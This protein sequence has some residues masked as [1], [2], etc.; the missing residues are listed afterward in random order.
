[1]PNPSAHEGEPNLAPAVFTVNVNNLRLRQSPGANGKELAK[2]REGALL[3]DL[4][5]VSDFTTKV[6]FRGILFDE[7]WLKVQMEDGL[8]GWVYAGGL[9]FDSNHPGQI[10]QQLHQKRL[11]AMFG[12][13]LSQRVLQYRNA[14]QDTKNDREMAQVYLEGSALR[15]TLVDLL[16]KHIAIDDYNQL[17]DLF[18]LEEALPGLVT[19]LVAEG[20]IYYLFFDYKQLLAKVQTTE[21]AADDAFVELCL[22]TYDLDSIEHFFPSWLMQTWDYGGHSLLGKG[23]HTQILKTMDN[24]IKAKNPFEVEILNLKEQL[25]ADIVHKGVSYWEPQAAIVQELTA[26]LKSNWTILSP[27]EQKALQE[28]LKQ[29]ENPEAH[30]IQVNLRSGIEQ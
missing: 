5:A 20:T 10:V 7:P 14:Y 30:A 17:P 9:R 1:M 11:Q 23:I 27:Q 4:G 13:E 12:Q 21:G 18:W 24:L 29:F 16:E 3:K 2:L 6:K 15:D 19:A 8:Q 28:R 26:L 22:Q 25:I